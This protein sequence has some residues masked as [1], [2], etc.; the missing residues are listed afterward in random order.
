MTVEA[1]SSGEFRRGWGTL[2]ASSAGLAFGVATLAVSYTIGV[3]MGPLQD[4]F[5]WSRAQILVASTITSVVVGSL[6][7]GVGW[8]ADR[9][10]VRWMIIG[11]QFGFA[12]GFFALAVFLNSLTSLYVLYFLL[13]LVGVATTAVAFAKLITAQFVKHRGLA[14]GLA[15]S[16]SGFCAFIVPPYLSYVVETF[17]WRAG[18]FA[19]G[20]LPLLIALPLTVLFIGRQ[21]TAKA[22]TPI[23]QKIALVGTASDFTF[24]QAL[25][26]YR[27]WA[28]FMIFVLGSC[29]MTGLITNYVP[30]L[31]DEGYSATQA[32]TMAGSFGISVVVGRIVVGF[33][34]DR[35]W[36]PLVGCL[37]FLPAAASIA[38]LAGGGLSTAALVGTILMSGFAAGAEVDLMGF[39]VARYFGLRHFGKIYAGIYIG[40]ALA[41]GFTTPLLGAARDHYGNYSAGL[42]VAAVALVGA[43]LLLISLG[44]YPVLAESKQPS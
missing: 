44:P 19:I 7:L 3:L 9:I 10:N 2:L 28:T 16:G 36:A 37:I 13:A 5:G 27:F 20:L 12:L 18:Y 43:A 14:L 15:M 4:E 34:I 29:V 1:R 40:F 11:S 6:T 22:V 23:P 33:L 26:S 38:L 24:K 30:I 42:Y 39:L 31:E 25:A 41:P 32:A 17:G 35:L 21:P 8:L